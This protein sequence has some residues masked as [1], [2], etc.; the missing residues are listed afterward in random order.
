MARCRF[1]Q[2]QITRLAL[3]DGEWIE[4]KNELS[5]GEWFD[6]FTSMGEAKMRRD[7]MRAQILAYVVNWSLRDATGQPE[8]FS[9]D[10]LGHLD[11]GTYHE[12]DE[13]LSAHIN[14]QTARRDERK[15][16]PDGEST[17]APIS[18]SAVSSPA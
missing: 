14:A 7:L 12:I 1:V 16:D 13:A 17:S 15:N 4:V 11:L 5:V 6:M 3:S 9:A 10:S 8:K 2:P 18:S